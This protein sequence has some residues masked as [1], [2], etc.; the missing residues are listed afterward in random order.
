MYNNY[1]GFSESPFNITPS[2]RFYFRTPSCEEV[3][4]IVHHGIETRK[5]VIAVTGLPGTG[6]TLLLKFLVR[7]L[8][9]KVKA[10]IVRN[11]HTDLNGLL[12]LLL[13]RLGLY[14]AA[15]TAR[16]CLIG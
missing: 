3:L 2:S 6:K 14:A 4:G 10:V 13:N 5:G 9:P 11:P 15:M 8:D 16:L 7:D 1:F 12:R